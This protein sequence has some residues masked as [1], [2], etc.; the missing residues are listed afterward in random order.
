MFNHS[1]NRG[2][3]QPSRQHPPQFYLPRNQPPQLSPTH[4]TILPPPLPPVRSPSQTYF[5]SSP[6]TH[7]RMTVEHHRTVVQM[8][9]HHMTVLHHTVVQ[10][11]HMTV[12]H[13]K[14]V[15]HIAARNV[16]VVR[17]MGSLKV[18]PRTGNSHCTVE[19][20]YTVV[21]QQYKEVDSKVPAQDSAFP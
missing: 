20:H 4:P 9:E 6:R 12:L 18:E 1:R 15:A 14:R 3:P 13:H 21:V 17:H 2:H 19:E 8:V 5:S 16:V 11:H 7:Q 10:D